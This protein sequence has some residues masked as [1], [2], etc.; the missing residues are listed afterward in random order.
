ML[1]TSLEQALDV[2]RCSAHLAAA[3]AAARAAMP[4]FA[5]RLVSKKKKRLRRGGFDLD[6]SYIWPEPDAATGVPAAPAR[7]ITMGCPCENGSGSAERTHA[8]GP[9]ELRAHALAGLDAGDGTRTVR[10]GGSAVDEWFRNPMEQVKGYLEEFHAERYKVFNFCSERWYDAAHFHGRLSRYPFADHNCPPLALISAAMED[11]AAWL[12]AHPENV[13]VFHCKAGKGRAGLMSCCLLLHMGWRPTAADAMAFYGQQRTHNGQGVTIPSQR[14]FVEYYARALAP[15]IGQRLADRGAVLDLDTTRPLRL[16]TVEVAGTGPQWSQTAWSSPWLVCTNSSG[17][18]YRAD[19]ATAGVKWARA[20]ANVVRCELPEH[21]G[22][23]SAGNMHLQL[24]DGRKKKCGLWISTESLGFAGRLDDGSECVGARAQ[25]DGSGRQRSAVAL[26][27]PKRALDKAAS[28][29]SLA[30]GFAVVLKLCEY[31]AAPEPAPAPARRPPSKVR[32]LACCGGKPEPQ[33]SAQPKAAAGAARQPPM[34][35]ELR[36]QPEDAEAAPARARRVFRSPRKTSSGAGS[37]QITSPPPRRQPKAGPTTPVAKASP[38]PPGAPESESESEWDTETE[39][40]TEDEGEA[41]SQSQVA[42]SSRE[43]GATLHLSPAST[44]PGEASWLFNASSSSAVQNAPAL[45]ARAMMA[46]SAAARQQKV[47]PEADT[48][49]ARGICCASPQPAQGAKARRVRSDEI[50]VASETDTE[51]ETEEEEESE[52]VRT[53]PQPE[54][55]PEEA[56]EPSQAE[57]EITK[58]LAQYLPAGRMEEEEAEPDSSVS[59]AFEESQSFAQPELE[60]EPEPEPKW[61][62]EPEPEPAPVPAEEPE[63]AVAEETLLDSETESDDDDIAVAEEAAA[64]SSL[65]SRLPPRSNSPPPAQQ[66]ASLDDSTALWEQERRELAIRHLQAA[67]RTGSKQ[68]YA[69]SASGRLPLA[70]RAQNSASAN[71]SFSALGNATLWG[72]NDLYPTTSTAINMQAS[73][74]AGV[75]ARE[76]PKT[77]RVE[78]RDVKPTT[79]SGGGRSRLPV[80]RTTPKR[81]RRPQAYG[82]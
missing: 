26:T 29:E 75:G 32:G 18:A 11:A 61:E 64:V 8:M 1:C 15:R 76:G 43:A 62:P 21:A 41:A 78:E 2:T 55:E 73:P 51:T 25:R 38:K 5:R 44:R 12:A 57:G 71:A 54:P 77:P 63:L 3:E 74:L 45:M 68:V 70:A 31:D 52:P 40:E 35:A 24:G 7:L 4:A 47:I 50:D 37:A 59:T 27:V 48:Q 80:S 42:G 20:A 30:Q 46:N 81:T 67:S 17:A 16:F 23:A 65:G 69:T 14:R 9:D 72:A 53:Q 13:V 19:G 22:L 60:P 39:T 79:P 58:L 56:K 66:Q 82:L 6:L 28:D 10:Q 36:P 34:R 49:T 33:P